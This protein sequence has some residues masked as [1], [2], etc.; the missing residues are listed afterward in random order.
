MPDHADL[1]DHPDYDVPDYDVVVLGAGPAGA[2]VAGLLARAGRT[3]ALV[4][5]ADGTDGHPA[6]PDRLSARSL[7]LSA[8]R[9]ETWEQAVAGRDARVR[10]AGEDDAPADAGVTVLRGPGR[11]VRPGRVEVDGAEH[12]YTDLVVCTGSEPVLPAL[13]GLADVP[14]WTVDEALGRAELPRRLVVLGG[15]PAGCELAQA[16]AAFGSRVTVVAESDR[17]LAA[18]APFIGAAIGDALR[19]L[20]ADLRLG[21]RLD[22]AEPTDTGLRLH[23]R[24]DAAIEAD[25]VLI[26][27]ARRPRVAGLG[28]ELLGVDPAAGLRADRTGRVG[29]HL[30]AA[31]DVTGGPPC[32][33]TAAHQADIVAANILGGRREADYRAIPRAVHTAPAAYA[34]G[35]S[36]ADT[37]PAPAGDRDDGLVA[38]GADLPGDDLCP[39]GGRIE[40]YADPSRGVLAG[41]AAVGPNAAD[42]MAEATLAI[43]TEIPL[44]TLADV[45]RARPTYGEAIGIAARE[46]IERLGRA[47]TS[48]EEGRGPHERT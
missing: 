22:R 4:E 26:A 25:R 18:E 28:L 20:G 9:G 35:V 6:Y 17:L 34:V 13:P 12:D 42:W 46:L 7:L 48:F 27:A 24:A 1:P 15:G 31:G 8:R 44:S 43:R 39:A 19:R 47:S 41:A 10:G 11:V 30:W 3:V 36:P 38:A 14:T 5:P 21:V 37:D 23:A 16:Y 2:R 33:H 40:L 29:R 32:P 45:V